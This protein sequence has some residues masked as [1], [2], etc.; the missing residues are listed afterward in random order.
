MVAREPRIAAVRSDPHRATRRCTPS[1]TSAP[2]GAAL[3]GGLYSVVEV[4]VVEFEEREALRRREQAVGLLGRSTAALR[5]TARR[6]SICADDAEDAFQRALVILLTKAPELPGEQATAWMHVVTRREAMAVRRER[7]RLLGG[8]S[9]LSEDERPEYELLPCGRRGPAERAEGRER[10]AVGAA[11]LARIK[12]QEQRALVLKAEGYS[13]AEIMEITG[14]TY[15]KVNRCMA[16]G[17]KA[18]LQHFARI[19]AGEGR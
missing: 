6:F 13:Y 3:A 15:T 12:P 7:E 18:F 17:R 16:E 19:E 4:N 1:V 11:A 8:R 9:A 2:G 10:V 14:W 5:R